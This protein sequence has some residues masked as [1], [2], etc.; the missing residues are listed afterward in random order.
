MSDFYFPAP[1]NPQNNPYGTPAGSS[2]NVRTLDGRTL[3]KAI[4]LKLIDAQEL[5]EELN[6]CRDA[7]R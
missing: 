1:V 3:F 5:C 2:Y 6:A 7:S 4:P